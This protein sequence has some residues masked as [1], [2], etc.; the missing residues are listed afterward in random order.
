MAQ[1]ND[2]KHIVNIVDRVECKKHK[3]PP[4]IPCFL[5]RKSSGNGYFPAICNKRA[6]L[7]GAN[8]K[9]SEPAYQVKK[10]SAKPGK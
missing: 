6:V 4:G 8:G 10:R 7:A 9:I 3:R 2:G 5:L 1:H